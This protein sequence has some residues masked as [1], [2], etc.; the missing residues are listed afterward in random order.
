LIITNT[1]IFDKLER[2]MKTYLRSAWKW[3]TLCTDH[4]SVGQ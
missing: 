3:Y 2:N 1:N 4:Y